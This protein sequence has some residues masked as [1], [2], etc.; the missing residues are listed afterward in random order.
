MD[1][2]AADGATRRRRPAGVVVI[3]VGLLLLGAA[4][5]AA[6]VLAI[7]GETAF[8]WTDVPILGEI[9]HV[10]TFDAPT[11]VIAGACLAVG[12][13]SL[14]VGVGWWRLRPWGW[15]GVILMEAATLTIN[16]VA[17][18]VGRPDEWSMAVAILAVL[19]S[20]QR[21]ILVLFHQDEAA[22]PD[23]A[24]GADVRVVG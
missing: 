2:T 7:T 1:S 8:P 20:N 9:D 17:V 15:T 19:Y 21:R 16:L 12:V 10:V 4:S 11:W 23:L 13:T 24:R 5:I 3:A 14:V 22:A 6:G 18:V